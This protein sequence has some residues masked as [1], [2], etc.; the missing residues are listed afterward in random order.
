MFLSI[1]A[2]AQPK[3]K[4]KISES[5]DKRDKKAKDKK[6]T[7]SKSSNSPIRSTT[8]PL[9]S[10]PASIT[11]VIADNLIQNAQKAIEP[12]LSVKKAQKNNGT[13]DG[14]DIPSISEIGKPSE[15]T[16]F[17][18]LA[19]LQR[20]IEEAKRQLHI[21]GESD[22]DDFLNIRTDRNELDGDM[23]ST[24]R[25]SN[26]NDK[27][28]SMHK[29]G[30]SD[31]T[32]RKAHSR[33]VFD[34]KEDN[35]SDSNNA[36]SNEKRSVLNRLGS[37]NQTEEKD[38]P[39]RNENIIS[40]SAH[41]RMEQAIYVAPAQRSHGSSNVRNEKT[42]LPSRSTVRDRSAER[43]TRESRSERS[44]REMPRGRDT[45]EKEPADLRER[46]RQ[47][48][49]DLDIRRSR[50]ENRST[51]RTNVRSRSRTTPTH[52][53]AEKSPPKQ[54]PPKPTLASRI[55]SKVTVIAKNNSDDYSEEEIAV[56]V[57]S[58]IKVKPR[59]IVPKSKQACKNLLLR[60]V[61]EAQKSTALV[62][63]SA[64]DVKVGGGAEKKELY[65]KAFRQNLNKDNILVEIA[66]K[67]ANTVIDVDE[68]EEAENDGDDDEYVPTSLSQ[69]EDPLVYIP[70]VINS[71]LHSR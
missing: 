70:Q 9:R 54:S 8:P 44:T 43:S 36:S 7:G 68:M 61:A 42:T 13:S 55:G 17:D 37:R 15:H 35:R 3:A 30:D 69:D 10:V 23:D 20:Q 1:L 67:R 56:P 33:I 63:P 11:D 27:A 19:D 48:N 64:I 53:R 22:D 47:K 32:G 16:K 18:E 38:R 4:R 6:R 24:S 66:A 21:G 31:K 5:T 2:A 39:E 46:V 34:D 49:R 71:T 41:R 52:G 57:N 25:D 65:T 60:A 26:S 50:A 40:L 28:K 12:P 59:P 58:V 51:E 14:F 45:K 29:D 62:K